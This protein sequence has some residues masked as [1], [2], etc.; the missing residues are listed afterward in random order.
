MIYG[1][2]DVIAK[3]K[4]D[5]D[6]FPTG[7]VKKGHFHMIGSPTWLIIVAEGYATA[8]SIHEASRFPVAVAW[9]AGNLQPVAQALKKRYRNARILIAADDDWLGKC[10]ACGKYTPVADEACQHCGQPHGKHNTGVTAASAAALAVGGA[11]VLPKFTDRGTHKWTD[12]NDLAVHETP[13]M[14]QDQIE[15]CLD[16]L[17]W[18]PKTAA[19][20]TTTGGRGEALKPLLTVDEACERFAL[21]YGSKGSI[22]DFQERALIPKSD[23]LDILPDHGWREWK[24]R[25]DRKVVR[26]DEVGFDPSGRDPKIKCNLWGGWPT[27][28]KSGCCESLLDLLAYLCNNEETGGHE[29]FQW[30]IKWCAYPLQHPGA[31]M[32]TALVLH[33]PQGAGKNMFFEAYGA[34]Y[35]HYAM[36]V[37]Q[38]A[39]EDKFNDWCSK[40]LF[41]IAD[42]VVARQELYHTKNK[43]KGLITGDTIRINPKHVTG[44]T[45]ANHVNIVFMSNE[46]QPLVLEQDD[47]RFAVIW[48]PEKLDQDFY[49]DVKEEIDSG[50]IA[51]LHDYLLNVDLGDFKPWTLPPMT[52]A[53]ADLIT[54]GLDSTERFIR[55]WLAGDL[56]PIPV[57]P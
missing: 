31:K 26:F 41:L 6:F 40:K 12:F 36:V 38:D 18:R 25:N 33:G 19:L 22:F 28:P 27:Q 45:E 52:Q 53:K 10:R 34:I 9:D 44:Y 48:T 39:V 43:I 35:D 16:E 4:R 30:V 55:A 15:A 20:A 46:V 5:K 29:L 8:A 51:A 3:K 23:V 13:S 11:Y 42:E 37:D 14:V 56:E 24:L 49:E 50:G 32:K 7:L 57:L 17:Q 21:I 2:P 47:R 54:L 1:D